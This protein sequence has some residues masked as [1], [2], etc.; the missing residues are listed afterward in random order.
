M[1]YNEFLQTNLLIPTILRG[2]R[3]SNGRQAVRDTDQ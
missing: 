2:T 3:K 1:I